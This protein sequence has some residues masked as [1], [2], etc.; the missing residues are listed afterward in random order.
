LV[1]SDAL[2]VLIPGHSISTAALRERDLGR[3]RSLE[4]EADTLA[5][6]ALRGESAPVRS[7]SQVPE[8]Q[9][10]LVD[11]GKRFISD[12]VGTTKEAVAAAG[13][14]RKAAT[15][16]VERKIDEVEKDAQKAA[17][18]IN[19]QNVDE[20]VHAVYNAMVAPADAV[21]E[22]TKNIPVVGTATRFAANLN[23]VLVR[24][25]EQQAKE[26]ATGILFDPKGVQPA[27]DKITKRDLED[28]YRE[29]NKVADGAYKKVDEVAAR[30]KGDAVL[31]PLTSVMGYATKYEV[32]GPIAGLLKHTVDFQA[33]IRH[34]IAHPASTAVGLAGTALPAA[35]MALPGVGTLLTAAT[36]LL[37]PSVQDAQQKI[38]AAIPGTDTP[39]ELELKSG[40]SRSIAEKRYEEI[41]GR[42]LFDILPFLIPGGGAARTAKLAGSEA[43]VAR[44]ATKAP[45]VID[46]AKGAAELPEAARGVRALESGNVLGRLRGLFRNPFPRT[47]RGVVNTARAAA[48]RVVMGTAEALEGPGLARGGASSPFTEVRTAEGVLGG[49]TRA[50][51]KVRPSTPPSTQVAGDLKPATPPPAGEGSSLATA[52]DVAAPTADAP[53]PPAPTPTPA[54]QGVEATKP[55]TPPPSV[56]SPASTTARPASPPRAPSATSDISVQAAEG[57]RPSTPVSTTDSPTVETMKPVTAAQTAAPDVAATP[58][59]QGATTPGAAA[60]GRRGGYRHPVPQ[61]QPARTVDTQYGRVQDRGYQGRLPND[62]SIGLKRDTF[63]WNRSNVQRM[64]DGRPPIGRDG[65]PV[66]LHHRAQQPQGP[67][68]EYEATRHQE[69]HG[70]MHSEDYT[71]IDRQEF[72]RQRA[73]YW[74]ERARDHLR[75]RGSITE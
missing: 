27:L 24:K 17:Y 32:V 34:A 64:L 9:F 6:R 66:V 31:G 35:G 50:A 15:E 52:S 61:V 73:R 59:N 1:R 47:L 10:S 44:L 37:Q 30:H 65:K 75:A 4:N 21:A 12:P 43:E 48:A 19:K 28:Q 45:E 40:Y 49:E 60:R 5:D 55:A 7:G 20:S 54:G 67:L 25:D 39:P 29:I 36:P 74:I 8:R 70:L 63:E 68:D 62:P 13:E 56:S 42:I 26:I 11:W 71:R 2:D 58:T 38:L 46:V 72:A 16:Y 3:R 51:E 41:S 23:R 18:N 69:Q 53:K 57:G 22:K 33:D 14:V